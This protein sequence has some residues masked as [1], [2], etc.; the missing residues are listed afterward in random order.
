MRNFRIM[1][2]QNRESINWIIS[3]WFGGEEYK[4]VFSGA[5]KRGELDYMVLLTN[6]VNSCIDR[7]YAVDP[8]VNI[9]LDFRRGQK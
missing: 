9:E 3:E 1:L 5:E 8:H 4:E 2:I 6:V 7:L